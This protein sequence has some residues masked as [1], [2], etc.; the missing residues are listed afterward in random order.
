MS[1]LELQEHYLARATA[2][3]ADRHGADI[4][5]M[6]ADVLTRWESLL[7]R[8]RVDPMQCAQ[9]LDWVAKLRMLEAFRDRDNLPW[10]SP[11]LALVDLQYSDV[12]PEK[13]LYHRLVA[14][15]EMQVMV[16]GDEVAAAMGTPPEDTR[17]YFR[18]RCLEKFGSSV[19]GASWDSLIFDLGQASLVR[20]PMMDPLRGTRTHVETLLDE[21]SSAQ[22]LVS[23]LTGG[24]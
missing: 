7:Q 11:R 19:V 13:G 1:A 9:E 22:E 23:H 18:G 24:S 20:I 15:G 16:T 2:F 3:V 8:L 5:E 17:A 6:T 21:C 12:R 4:D 10:S 14:R